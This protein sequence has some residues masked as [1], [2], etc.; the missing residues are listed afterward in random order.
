[1][2][3]AIR[4]GM[5]EDSFWDKSARAVLLLTQEEEHAANRNRR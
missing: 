1:M 5:G 4:A 3:R 2:R